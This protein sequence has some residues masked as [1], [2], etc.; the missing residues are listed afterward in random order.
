MII[1]ESGLKLF[2]LDVKQKITIYTRFE[3]QWEWIFYT[4]PY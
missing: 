4:K 2:L 1:Y 3:I